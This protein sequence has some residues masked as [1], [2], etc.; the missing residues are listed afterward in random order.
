MALLHLVFNTRA[1]SRVFTFE[2]LASRCNVDLKSVETLLLQALALHLIEGRVDGLESKVEV[3]WL[4]PRVVDK[5][6]IAALAARVKEWRAVAKKTAE[7][8]GRL[9][10][11]VP[12]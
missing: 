12:S 5:D 1:D 8:V 6:D 10:Q 11:E 2:T 9:A 3:T 7:N 4:Q